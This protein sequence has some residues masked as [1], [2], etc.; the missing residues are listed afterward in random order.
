MRRSK[1]QRKRN[2]QQNHRHNH[3]GG[4]QQAG[5]HRVGRFP[6]FDFA[7]RFFF[8]LENGDE[9]RCQRAFAQ[10]P[11][12]KI[13]N[14]EGV[15][16]GVVDP[17]GAQKKHVS[18]LTHQAE[19]AAEQG[20][21]GHRAGGFQHFRH[22]RRL[23]SKAQSPKSK[24][25]RRFYFAAKKRKKR[26]NPSPILRLLCLLAAKSV[27]Q[28]TVSFVILA[29]EHSGRIKIMKARPIIK[30]QSNLPRVNIYEELNWRGLI[31]DCTDPNVS[32]S[33][34]H[35]PQT[36]PG[37]WHR[38]NIT[39]YCGFDPTGDSL[40]VGSLVPLLT[41]RRFQ[42]AGHTP[43]AVA[44][45]ATGSIGDPSGKTQER[46]LLTPE[47]LQQNIASMAAQLRRWLDFDSPTNAARLVDNASWMAGVS[48]LDFLRNS[49]RHFSIHLGISYAVVCL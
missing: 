44:G 7:V 20:G 35:V 43:I 17:G 29:C 12:E 6:H 2:A 24:V 9:R 34:G 23:K 32:V 36:D 47:I 48:F 13:G 46:Q 14:G 22:A 27:F 28:S 3:A 5:D 15:L 30:R 18:L 31:A 41:L 25:H 8:L 21:G 49:G 39:L 33:G 37:L 40:H 1:S 4:N 45:G 11:P 26:K 16:K 10:Q 19:H 38:K 42:L